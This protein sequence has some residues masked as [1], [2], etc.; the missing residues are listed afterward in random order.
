[1]DWSRI[2]RVFKARVAG[3]RA[4]FSDS[5]KRRLAAWEESVEEQ[6]RGWLLKISQTSEVEEQVPYYSRFI[7]LFAFFHG[8]RILPF[9]Q[10]AA[11]RFKD[12][13]KQRVRIGT[14]DLKI[15]SIVLTQQAKLLSANLRDFQK[16][17]NL[18]V[19]SW[20]S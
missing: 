2:S 20:L 3:V 16:V 8:W 9:D 15:A 1:M 4:R 6:A 7:E 14:M 19:E 12:L 10:Q 18:D 5:Q 17:A 11:A 13:R